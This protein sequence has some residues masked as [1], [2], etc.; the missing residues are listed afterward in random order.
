MID[1]EEWAHPHLTIARQ[2]NRA[3]WIGATF[4]WAL[5]CQQ[6][7]RYEEA[8]RVLQEIVTVQDENKEDAARALTRLGI[9]DV[10]SDQSRDH[11]ALE[12]FDRAAELCA[13]KSSVVGCK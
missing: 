13:D 11:M 2:N 10:L 3:H 6:T 5:F 4:D 7:E 9:N 1:T 12:R 8:A